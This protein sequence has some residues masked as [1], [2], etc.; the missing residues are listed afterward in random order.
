MAA[1]V[2]A[3]DRT[4]PPRRHRAAVCLTGLLGLVFG[5]AVQARDLHGAPATYRAMLADLRPGDRLLLAPGDYHQGLP[6]VDVAGTAGAPITV[7]GAQAQGQG[8]TRFL[9]R[10]GANTVSLRR[11]AHLVIDALLLDGRD[12]PVDAVTAEAG[13]GTARHVTLSRLTIIGHGADQQ[14]VGI[15]TKCTAVGW[16]VR[17]NTIIGAG[18]GM[19]FGNSDGSAPFIAGLIEDNLVMDTIGYNMQVKHQAPWPADA[20]LPAAPVA[21]VLR[22]N[23]F[24]KG[25]GSSTGRM[26]RPNLLLGSQPLSGPGASDRFLVYGNVF[27][28]NPGEA[29]LQAEG[30]LAVYNNAF[31]NRTGDAVV[32][33]PHYGRPRDVAVFQNTI[34]ASGRGLVLTG[35]DPDHV[36]TALGNVIVAGEPSSQPDPAANLLAALPAAST[37]LRL[38]PQLAGSA[39]NLGLQRHPGRRMV[40]S[41][42]TA[43]SSLPAFDRD[44]AG[45]ER[46]DGRPGA[47]ATADGDLSRFVAALS[48][49]RQASK[50]M[51]GTGSATFLHGA[52]AT[53]AAQR[54]PRHSA[55]P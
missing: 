32:V 34:V 36:Q 48:A 31:V 14:I 19:Y 5:L 54:Q 17:G 12:L 27:L 50:S 20:G 49:A 30:N 47:F 46:V 16:V 21:T 1:A 40:A 3:T 42:P 51:S 6:L 22:R 26:A 2:A 37:V 24:A 44:L 11:V 15:S 25:A 41:W 13:A 33:R 53:G 7:Q 43:L 8:V 39:P 38:P 52:P 45:L 9:A 35:G 29:L 23:V 18:T 28:D 55:S 10:P 4:P